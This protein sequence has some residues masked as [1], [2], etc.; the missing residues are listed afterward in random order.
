MVK[1]FVATPTT[2]TVSDSQVHFMR[3]ITKRY[4]DKIELIYPKECVRRMFH[5]A[6][7]NGMVDE[8]LDS[9]ADILWFLDSDIT[10][11]KHVLD[12]I[13]L[14]GDK[15]KLAGAPYPVFMS[16]EPGAVQQI[17]MAVYASDG[18]GMFPGS[19]PK[20]GTAFVGGLATGCLFIRREVIERLQ[21]PYFEFK[22][23]GDSRSIA[24]GEDMGFC[25]KVNA[26]GYQFFVDF[27]M[28]CKH[29]KSVCLLEVNNYAIEYANK[30]VITYDK[31]IR[32]QVENLV[33][34]LM[35]AHEAKK[36]PVSP[37]LLPDSPFRR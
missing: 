34:K 36:G 12:L 10:P 37:I 1:V 32:G 23:E 25:R 33:T 4:S 16:P 35:Q 13:T 7:R 8:F 30:S 28:V 27:D 29:Q 5:D 6:A 22:Y 3:E 11:P 2:G 9:D 24:E 19:V 15:W 26:L 31:Q 21:K 17:V 20:E 18:K 14:H